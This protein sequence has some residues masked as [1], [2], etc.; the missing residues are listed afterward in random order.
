MQKDSIKERFAVAATAAGIPPKQ[1]ATMCDIFDAACS[2]ES[3]DLK[4]GAWLEVFED[5]TPCGCLLAVGALQAGADVADVLD[6]LDRS[7][8]LAVYRIGKRLG[9]DFDMM[10]PFLLGLINGWDGEAFVPPV[11][12]M[13]LASDVGL[14]VGAAFAEKYLTQE[15]PVHSV[16]RYSD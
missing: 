3:Y 6:D 7:E 14:A 8:V 10:A 11:S 4:R 12:D 15:G 2:S 13:K 1:F 5:G 16:W 9:L